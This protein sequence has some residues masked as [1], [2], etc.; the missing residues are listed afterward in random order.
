MDTLKNKSK[1]VK[2]VPTVQEK[3]QSYVKN[4]YKEKNS[5]R[6]LPGVES[7]ANPNKKDTRM[8]KNNISLPLSSSLQGSSKERGKRGVYQKQK[9]RGKRYAPKSPYLK[10]LWFRER[11]KRIYRK[12]R[13]IFKLQDAKILKHRRRMYKWVTRVLTKLYFKLFI[14]HSK[15]VKVYIVS[16]YRNVI[17]TITTSTGKVLHRVSAGSAKGATFKK[18]LRKKPYPATSAGKEVAS[19][20]KKNKVRKIIIFMKGVGRGKNRRFVLKSLERQR[21]LILAI[22]DMTAL[23]HNGCRKPK[24]RRL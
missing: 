7:R 2:P 9:K 20:L 6:Q 11:R 12:N 22:K 18:S 4:S 17:V 3:K 16:T 8:E 13:T 23:P 5:A 24:K 10:Y 14:K 19:W 15:L 21:I 1:A